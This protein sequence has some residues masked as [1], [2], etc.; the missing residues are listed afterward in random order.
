M[1]K[2]SAIPQELKELNQWVLWKKTVIRGRIAKIPYSI[3]GQMAR[4]NNSGTWAA[5][6]DVIDAYD[7]GGYDGI[8]FVFTTSDEYCGIDIDHCVDYDGYK[9]YLSDE[10]QKIVDLLDSYS[11]VSPS[12]AGVHIIIKGKKPNTK[13]RDG[14][15]E[16]YEH[17]RY[18]CMTG[19][20]YINA[21][22]TIENRQNQL[23]LICGVLT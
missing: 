20:D 3:N 15:S 18:F 4:T 7:L 23:N 5:F 17:G 13:C 16:I 6:N 21:R 1:S 12:G 22:N 8:G 19:A 11:E 10:A 14:F 2:F 9:P